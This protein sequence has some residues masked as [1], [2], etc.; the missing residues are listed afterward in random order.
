MMR[1]QSTELR[2][3]VTSIVAPLLAAVAL[4]VGVSVAPTAGLAAVGDP[5]VGSWATYQWVSSLKEQ[6]PVLVKQDQPGGQPSWTVV[7]ESVVPIPLFVTYSILSGDAKSYLL[8]IVTRQSMD[9]APLSVTQITVDRA[10]GKALKSVIQ[11]PK[12]QIVTPES[13]LRPFRQATV[14]GTAED[15]AVPAGRFQT[16]RAPY[17]NGTVWVSDQVPA[18]GF[19]KAQLT[20]GQLELLKSGTSG[21]QDLLRS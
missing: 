20:N 16:V 19:A 10:S 11:R 14:K 17:Q 7:T 21:A 15:V 3:V 1:R 9:G 2:V 12:G 6:V 5:V 4:A 8:Q 13:G 18:M